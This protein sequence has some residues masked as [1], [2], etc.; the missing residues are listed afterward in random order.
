MASLLL[1]ADVSPQVDVAAD[2]LRAHGHRVARASTSS[3]ALSL[4]A[5]GGIDLVVL[6]PDLADGGA[7]ELL[8][9]AGDRGVAVEPAALRTPDT[10]QAAI[11]VALE[12]VRAAAAPPAAAEPGAWAMAAARENLTLAALEA[13]YIQTILRENGGHRGR[14][15]KA[16]GIDP[17]TLYNKLGPER[18]R[19]K[20]N[21]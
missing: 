8:R 16:L 20:P 1:V 3:E 17:K 9:R 5:A 12:R 13:V 14:T 7:A 15:A 4:L 6:D 18:P 19:R 21:G 2:E 10:I 11:E